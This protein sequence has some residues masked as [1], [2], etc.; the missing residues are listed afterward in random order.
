MCEILETRADTTAISITLN[1]FNT[2]LNEPKHL[3]DR[4]DLYPS[5]KFLAPTLTDIIYTPLAQTFGRPLTHSFLLSSSG[6]KYIF[7]W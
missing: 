1:S 4:A 5:C 3:Q 6:S 2:P 7:S